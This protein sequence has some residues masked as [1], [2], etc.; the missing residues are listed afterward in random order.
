MKKRVLRLL[1]LM[2]AIL[3]ILPL[4][5]SCSNKSGGDDEGEGMQIDDQNG[6]VTSPEVTRA[7]LVYT[8][9]EARG[10]EDDDWE[11]QPCPFTDID[12]H[13]YEKHIIIAAC[14]DMLDVS[15]EKFHPNKAAT[16]EFAATM[17]AKCLGF[18]PKEDIVCTDLAQIQAPAYAAL[19]MKLGMFALENNNFLPNKP[20]ST[21]ELETIVALAEQTF[22]TISD[23]VDDRASFQYQKGVITLDE[24]ES[25][26]IVDDGTCLFLPCSHKTEELKEGDIL[27]LSNYASYRVLSVSKADDGLHVSYE[28]PELQ[29]VFSAIHVSGTAYGDVNS[30]QP[31]EGVTIAE[32]RARVS[33]SGS[34]NTPDLT[35]TLTFTKKLKNGFNLVITVD[36]NILSANYLYDIDL[37][38]ILPKVNNAYLIL[39]TVTDGYVSLATDDENKSLN[40]GNLDIPDKISLGVIPFI[41]YKR[42]GFV[43]EVFASVSAEGSVTVTLQSKGKMGVQIINN[44][45]RLVN[46]QRISLKSIALAGEF[47]A[48]M[49]FDVLAEIGKWDLLSF[50]VKVG[51]SAKGTAEVKDFDPFFFCVDGSLAPYLEIAL[52]E[53][54]LLNEWWSL[55]VSYVIWEN[56]KDNPYRTALHCENFRNIVKEC[57]YEEE[58]EP[59]EPLPP[60]E[61]PESDEPEEP[62]EPDKPIP[63]GMGTLRLSIKLSGTLATYF[64]DED[65]LEE[66]WDLTYRPNTLK[67]AAISMKWVG[68]SD[69]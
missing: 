41:G 51:Y 48:G 34:M 11:E 5:V 20:L 22:S 49:E 16:R 33:D 62:E 53:D 54:T 61:P 43:A 46:S 69:V 59:D 35:P 19:A 17:V 56:N 3:M 15:E 38:G 57:T 45:P 60:D 18:I 55:S 4:I 13:K 1:S 58:D 44:I 39:D 10:Y 24:A 42:V 66:M 37:S 64:S 68:F 12:G 32:S 50:K 8:L 63:G 52:M 27:S 26:E 67:G 2:M 65:I 6:T 9:I 40:A 7:Q 25:S 30:I 36:F 31:S 28:H 21:A 47:K 29:E 14:F 23:S